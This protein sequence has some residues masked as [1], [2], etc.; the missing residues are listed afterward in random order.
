[1][2]TK[3]LSAKTR[4]LHAKY[5]GYKLTPEQVTSLLDDVTTHDPSTN[6]GLGPLLL[7]FRSFTYTADMSDRESMLI[8]IER[9]LIPLSA[10]AGQGIDALLENIY[11]RGGQANG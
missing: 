3:K 2:V 6:A 11:R 10:A 7:L 5:T 4:N 9:E 8:L 1:M